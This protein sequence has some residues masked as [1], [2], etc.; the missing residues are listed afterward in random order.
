MQMRS[1][2]NFLLLLTCLWACEAGIIRHDSTGREQSGSVD[3]AGDLAVE[4]PEEAGLVETGSLQERGENAGTNAFAASGN[5]TA[6]RSGYSTSTTF[7][8]EQ[9]SSQLGNCWA[10]K[11]PASTPACTSSSGTTVCKCPDTQCDIDELASST[12]RTGRCSQK[13]V[14]VA[15]GHMNSQNGE[16][17]VTG[18]TEE[19][20]CKNMVNNDQWSQRGCVWKNGDGDE[21]KSR[22]WHGWC[23]SGYT[24]K[25]GKC[26]RK[27]RFIVGKNKEKESCW[28]SYWGG[29]CKNHETSYDEYSTS[30]Y[31]GKCVPYAYAQNRQE[32][33]CAWF[34]WNF[35]VACSASGGSCG[36]HACVLTT[37]NMK[38]YCDYATEQNWHSLF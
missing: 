36:G 9:D 17:D 34:G 19:V 22:P 14:Y 11:P 13:E 1:C 18:T 25:G 38:K 8:Y 21:S 2:N 3:A 5:A 32:C 31:E 7:C 35:L 20:Y 23:S 12:P 24:S 27:T 10:S 28:D 33:T 16:L 4:V 30:C 6:N 37:Q 29:K 26:K 15:G